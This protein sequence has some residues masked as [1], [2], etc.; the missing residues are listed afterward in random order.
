VDRHLCAEDYY[1]ESKSQSDSRGRSRMILRPR[2]HAE[3][4][5]VGVSVSGGIRAYNICFL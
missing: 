1:G 2:G 3:P 5:E 4:I